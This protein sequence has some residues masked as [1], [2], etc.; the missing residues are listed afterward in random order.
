MIRG[1]D[2]AMLLE[3]W[4][5]GAAALIDEQPGS[6]ATC[7]KHVARRE[8]HLHCRGVAIHDWRNGSKTLLMGVG[9]RGRSQIH[10]LS[11]AGF[12]PGTWTGQPTADGP[13]VCRTEEVKESMQCP[14]QGCQAIAQAPIE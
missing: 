9:R 7:D 10:G 13:L 6:I 2:E 14:Q 5:G 8:L 1:A 11:S 4:K 3:T 12:I